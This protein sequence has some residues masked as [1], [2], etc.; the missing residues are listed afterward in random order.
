[1]MATDAQAQALHAVTYR[2][3][4][5]AKQ[6]ESVAKQLSDCESYLGQLINSG[7]QFNREVFQK[8]ISESNTR[9][10]PI[11]LL[12][13]PIK[14]FIE[15]LISNCVLHLGTERKATLLEDRISMIQKVSNRESQNTTSSSDMVSELPNNRYS[16]ERIDYDDGFYIGEVSNGVRHGHGKFYHKNG[17]YCEGTFVRD[18][19]DGFGEFFWKNGNMYKGQFKNNKLEGKGVVYFAN[20]DMYEG[21]FADDDKHGQGIFYYKDDTR[22]NGHFVRGKKHGLGVRFYPNDER[23]EGNYVDDKR[24]GRGIYYFK[25]GTQEMRVYERGHLKHSERI[26]E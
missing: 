3:L 25:D 20:G 18:K 12:S 22:F 9:I 10:E 19:F 2:Y 11:E 23:Y 15:K 7:R 26:Y 17:N 21:E 24:D 13:K 8:I 5:M 4:A 16:G 6:Y 14:T 1:M